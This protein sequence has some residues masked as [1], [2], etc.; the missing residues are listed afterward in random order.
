VDFLADRTVLVTGGTGS[1]G[2]AILSRL[3]ASR[4]AL[5]VLSRDEAKQDALRG[6]YRNRV[7]FVTG[8]VRDLATVVD[9]MR[10]ADYVFHAA[11]LKQVPN[12]ERF[13][14]EAVRTNV[15]GAQNVVEATKI[16]RP[17]AVV[18]ISTDKAVEP[19][20]AMGLTKALME[21][22]VLSASG[23][24]RM[25]C[26]RYG[27]VV[28]SRGSVV[29]LFLDRIARGQPL[30]ITDPEMTRFLLCLPDAVELVLSAALHGKHGELWVSKMPAATVASIA[31]A[32]CWIRGVDA[33]W[34][35][36]G[37]RP[38]EKRHEVLVTEDEMSRARELPGH[39]VVDREQRPPPRGEYTSE[40]TD[41]LDVDGVVSLLRKAGI[42]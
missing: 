8:D 34:R 22:L 32:C 5:R 12:C 18:A 7:D 20:N 25:V 31:G 26:V 19:L 35:L 29:P 13:P 10:G 15:L 9:A 2:Q 1:F 6:E 3:A 11:A 4:A 40:N 36:V 21:R 14:M 39:F 16:C 30:P 41:R 42:T 37:T 23:E 33:Q 28:G 38:G 24:S 27:N 17:T